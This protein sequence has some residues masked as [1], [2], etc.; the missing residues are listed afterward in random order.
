VIVNGLVLFGVPEIMVENDGEL[1]VSLSDSAAVVDMVSDVQSQVEW[2]GTVSNRESMTSS[3]DHCPGSQSITHRLLPGDCL[4][5]SKLFVVITAAWYC[6]CRLS[7]I[8]FS[9]PNHILYKV[10]PV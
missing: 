9:F 10:G 3:T 5:L 6:L 7:L 8:G 1:A 4:L 2:Q